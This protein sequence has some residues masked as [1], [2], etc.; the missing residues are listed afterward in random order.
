MHCLIFESNLVHYS[1]SSCT[2]TTQP[3][4]HKCSN[5][6]RTLNN[7]WYSVI[8]LLALLG[9]WF[10]RFLAHELC[11][12]DI[13]IFIK[14]VPYEPN[15]IWVSHSWKQICFAFLFVVLC[16]K[17]SATAINP[18]NSHLY[19]DPFD[20]SA[21]STTLAQ[22]NLGVY[23]STTIKQTFSGNVWFLRSKTPLWLDV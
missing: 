18:K 4:T 20:P 13:P 17:T 3:Q 19:T 11:N 2:Y 21:T 1:S 16:L 8:P 22:R 6:G 23:A 12:N 5:L 15:N 10:I 7:F 9:G 14:G